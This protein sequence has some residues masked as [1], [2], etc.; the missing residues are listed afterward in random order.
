MEMLKERVHPFKTVRY[1]L[2]GILLCAAIGIACFMGGRLSAGDAAPELSSVVLEQRLADISELA[3]V[4]YAYT[5]MAQFQSSSEFYGVTLPFTTKSFILTYDGE[6]KAGVDLSK[7]K[8]ETG[9]S[10]V[11]VTLPEAEILSHEIDQDSIEVFD[12]KTSI[13]NPFT[14]EDYS[15]F[16]RDQTAAMEQKATDRGLLTQAREKAVNAVTELLSQVVPQT[17]T[18]K[19]E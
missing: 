15:A 9:V 3:T 8:I 2:L 5:N 4:T 11:T 10:S 17:Y 19:V 16:Q 18:L 14:V 1:V 7:A 6:I 12:E 13:F